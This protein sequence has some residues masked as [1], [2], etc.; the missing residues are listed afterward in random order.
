MEILDCF[1][2]TDE[3][4]RT[5]IKYVRVCTLDFMKLPHTRKLI[6]ALADALVERR[7]LTGREVKEILWAA[8]EPD[9]LK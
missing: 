2:G 1:T 6:L 8:G 7:Q 3:Q 5:L 4:L 9:R